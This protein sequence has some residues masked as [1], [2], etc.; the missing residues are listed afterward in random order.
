VC[1]CVCVCVS[2]YV[3]IEVFSRYSYRGGTQYPRL[4]PRCHPLF[5]TFTETDPVLFLKQCDGKVQKRKNVRLVVHI[6]IIPTSL[7]MQQWNSLS[8]DNAVYDFLTYWLSF[9]GRLLTDCFAVVLFLLL[10]TVTCTCFLLSVP[11]NAKAVFFLQ[12]ADS[13][14]TAH[15]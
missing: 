4:S 9:Q 7:M 14:S 1:V 13:C 10:W 15:L 8:I 2:V 12:F 11:L 6:F 5:G 3:C